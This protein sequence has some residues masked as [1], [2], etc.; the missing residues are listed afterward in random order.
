MT[1]GRT[2]TSPHGTT[3]SRKRL[4][5]ETARLRL[6]TVTVDLTTSEDELAERVSRVF[7]L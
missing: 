6:P 7:R 5:E 1:L 2:A 4:R 3:C